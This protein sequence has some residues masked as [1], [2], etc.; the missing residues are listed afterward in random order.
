MAEVITRKREIQNAAAKLFGQKGFAASSV[1]EIA[2]A[3]GLGA[4]SLYNHMA[5]KEDLLKVI[6]FECAHK[7]LSGMEEIQQM[8]V[9]VLTRIKLLIHLH[10]QIALKDTSS[11]TVFNDEWRHLPPQ[12]LQ[13]FLAYRRQYEKAF[14]EILQEGMEE[15]SIQRTDAQL[16]FQ[17]I[18]S[19][20]QWLHRPS[21]Q[22]RN[23][24]ELQHELTSFILNGISK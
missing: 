22:K 14:I 24:T 15:K 19:S 1:R 21:G 5:S 9:P 2:Q 16:I 10:I 7:F 4:A 6:C 3:V 17:F 23:T 18:L 8:D 12:D 20:L 13:T 11:V